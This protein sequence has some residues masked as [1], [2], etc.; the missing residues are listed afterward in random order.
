M[1]TDSNHKAS[2]VTR[3]R[4]DYRYMCTVGH[5]A[6]LVA[7]CYVSVKCTQFLSTN[8]SRAAFVLTNPIEDPRRI[9][10]IIT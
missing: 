5:T 1:V 6:S 9:I 2:Y 7:A 10:I 4:T 8:E 3:V